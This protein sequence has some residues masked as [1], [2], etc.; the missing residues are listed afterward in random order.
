MPN[1]RWLIALLTVLHRFVYLVTDG[2]IGAAGLGRKF[3]LLR[4]VGRKSGREYVVPL[5]CVEDAG[6]F[7]VVGSNGGD[8]RNPAWWLNLEAR[9]QARIQYRR[10]RR[11]VLARK[12]LGEERERLWARCL[13]AYPFYDRYEGRA[14]RE[15]PVVVLDPRV[16]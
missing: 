9:P 4:H 12:A 6:R 7:V 10:E 11:E 13:A 3:L 5:L 14:G 1:I 2:R 16:A 15:I 8:V